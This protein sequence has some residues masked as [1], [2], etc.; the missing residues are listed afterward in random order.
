[1]FA[2]LDKRDAAPTGPTKTKP[3]RLSGEQIDAFIRR[4]SFGRFV[5]RSAAH[6]IQ[7][8]N[9][10][11]F[12]KRLF[13]YD[14]RVG[15]F[16]RDRAQD[17]VDNIRTGGFTD[18][19]V[20][21]VAFGHPRLRYVEGTAVHEAMHVVQSDRFQ[22]LPVP[23]NEAVAEFFAH[24]LN[25]EFPADVARA[26]GGYIQYTS[27]VW[28]LVRLSKG[29]APDWAPL[30]RAYFGGAVSTLENQVDSFLGRGSFAAW[31]KSLVEAASWEH[32]ERSPDPDKAYRLLRQ[33]ASDFDAKAAEARRRGRQFREEPGD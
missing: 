12:A 16:S 21:Y 2:Q 24:V 20:G 22:R 28:A 4:S 31:I 19:R 23:V 29:A 13:E 10:P 11:E 25:E 5:T 32:D 17:D 1:M 6:K 26:R 14:I 7:Y 9:W 18:N 33:L 15:G 8:L 3:G 27:P 30:A